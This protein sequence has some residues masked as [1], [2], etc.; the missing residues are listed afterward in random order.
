MSTTKIYGIK[1]CDTVRKAVKWLEAN[2]QP[3][4]FVDFKK[5]APDQQLLEGWIGQVGL[6]KLF[7][8]RSTTWKKLPE[9]ERADAD[10]KAMIAWM[11]EYP[12]LIKRP[13]LEYQGNVHLGFKEAEYHSLINA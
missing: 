5:T 6:D 13:V 11:Q 1:N 2:Q 10:E 7:N 4:E 12:T 8:K 3:F 9:Q